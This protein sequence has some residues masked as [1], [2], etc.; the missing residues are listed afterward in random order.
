[1]QAAAVNA[2]QD[3]HEEYLPWFLALVTAPEALQSTYSGKSSVDRISGN[4][5]TLGLWLFW[6]NLPEIYPNSSFVQSL[7]SFRPTENPSA[8]ASWF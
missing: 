3:P 1:M 8:S 7:I 5:L 6:L 4:D 2:Q